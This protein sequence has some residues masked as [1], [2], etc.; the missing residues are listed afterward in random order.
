MELS[1]T[2]KHNDFLLINPTVSNR[3]TNRANK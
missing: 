2:S 3:P 1:P